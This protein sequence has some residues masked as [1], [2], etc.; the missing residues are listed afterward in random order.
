MSIRSAVAQTYLEPEL[1]VKMESA[2]QAN[3]EAISKYMRRLILKDLID[4]RIMTS[5][6]VAELAS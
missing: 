6:D 2:C 3:A 1:F 4:R 5:E